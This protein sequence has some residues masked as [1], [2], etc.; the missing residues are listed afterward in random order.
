VFHLDRPLSTGTAGIDKGSAGRN[1]GTM[2]QLNMHP[3]EAILTWCAEAAP[4][5]WYP[6]VFV[7]KSGIPRE[8]LDPHLDTLRLGGLIRLTDWVQGPGQ[9]YAI[10]PEGTQVLQNPRLLS[11]LRTNGV[12]PRPAPPALVPVRAGVD[13]STWDRGELIRGVLLNPSRPVVTSAIFL[14]NVLVFLVGMGMVIRAQKP[15][16]KYVYGSDVETIDA[17]GAVNAFQVLDGQWWRLIT[18]CFVHVGLLHLAVNMY[19]LYIFGPLVERLFGHWRFLA[20]YLIAGFGGSCIGVLFQYACAGASGAICGLLGA[21]AA[22][23][24]LNRHYL[25][26]QLVRGWMRNVAV[27]T[28]LLVVVSSMPG[29]SWS[30]HLGGAVLGILS[31]A[32]LNFQMV[33]RGSPR[34]VALTG[35][36]LLPVACFAVLSKA[37]DW[38]KTWAALARQRTAVIQQEETEQINQTIL[39]KVHEIEE[40]AKQQLS[41][42]QARRLI[43]QPPDRRDRKAVDAMSSGSQKATSKLAEAAAVLRAAGPYRSRRVESARLSRLALVEEKIKLFELYRKCL[44]R[45]A[46]WMPAD[47]KTLEEQQKKLEEARERWDRVAK[48]GD[49]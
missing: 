41:E 42:A 34:W 45:G 29:I 21:F 15:L 43:G 16:E 8:Q 9:G 19:A 27:N 46:R 30:G 18:S 33:G 40:A 2:N 23:T 13:T 10:T 20:I 17:T 36:L 22:W 3:L 44:E 4:N 35:A 25:P 31:A 7:Q 37:P 49:R 6:S 12:P 1:N 14:L 5:P 38:N 47:D 32:L 39:P 26:P 11:R 24:F 28:V 48:G